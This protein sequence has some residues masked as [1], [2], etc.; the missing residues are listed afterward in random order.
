MT[1]ASGSPNGVRHPP[2]PPCLR[3]PFYAYSTR[4]SSSLSWAH[5]APRE[6][7]EEQRHSA[8]V[9]N[10]CSSQPVR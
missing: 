10:C 9:T 8:R 7:E 5:V 2:A 1:P 6:R 3:A 4:R